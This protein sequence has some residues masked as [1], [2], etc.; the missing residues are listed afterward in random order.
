MNINW[1]PGH[2]KKT[3]ER[4]KESSKLV[5]S[6]V[7]LLDARIPISSENP[8]IS[9]I[10]ESKKMIT[11]LNKEDL[12]DEEVNRKWLEH[13][14]SLGRE[15]Y[16]LNSV[17]RSSMKKFI[18][19]ITSGGKT[20]TRIMIVGIPNVG[21]STLINTLSRRKGLKT[22]NRPG[23]TKTNQWLKTDF[24]IDLLDTPGV[25]WHKFEDRETGINL[26][27]TGA[28]KDEILDTEELA[29]ILIK[30]LRE[31]YPETIENRFGIEISDKADHEVLEE[32]GLKRGAII[33]GGEVDYFK[34]ANLLLNDYR[35]GIMGR[36]SLEEV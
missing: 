27:L 13:F 25:L 7:E 23:V 31:R 6:V 12:A 18:S 1:F 29:I 20:R 15:A 24:G 26:A 21:K 10:F 14:K 35:K 16:L 5:D 28:I 4:L 32:I 36:I 22:G 19:G 30:K 3:I 9:E 8:I 33:K 11:V 2:M 17:D 34:A